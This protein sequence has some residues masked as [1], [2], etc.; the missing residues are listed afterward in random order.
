MDVISV[1]E[2]AGLTRSNA[3]VY[4]TLSRLGPTTVGAII[5]RTKLHKATVYLA[6]S[7]L[8]KQGLVSFISKGKVKMWQATHPTV[9]LESLKEREE[10]LK[11]ILPLLNPVKEDVS[12]ATVFEGKEGL[13]KLFR[14]ILNEKMYYH[15]L[16]G[17]KLP[18]LLGSFFYQ[19]QNM[20]KKKNI[21][22]RI[23]A[24]ETQRMKQGIKDTSGEF[25]YLPE[26]YNS[27]I[28]TIIYGKKIA[29]I[30]W[31]ETIV[32]LLESE[33][34]AMAYKKYFQTLW[35]IAKK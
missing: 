18:E 28:S 3:T 34:T 35:M 17:V 25:R 32:F 13:K 30:S 15:L 22:A 14:E 11:E 1:L 5:S 24:S 16:P 31:K 2:K 4:S 6:L 12:F 8:L 33:E 19:F 26:S 27:P 10:Q 9:I 20:K 29:I 21:H 23:I 7:S